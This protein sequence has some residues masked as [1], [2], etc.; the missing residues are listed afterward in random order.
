LV[1]LTLYFQLLG[2]PAFTASTLVAVFMA[3]VAVGGMLG[4]VLGDAAAI[5]WPVHGRIV[6]AQISVA[7][8]IP[9]AVLLTKVSFC[10][11]VGIFHFI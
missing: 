8:G 1:Y 10:R 4:G 5:K 6:V 9:F 3:G 11:N 2:F 7:S